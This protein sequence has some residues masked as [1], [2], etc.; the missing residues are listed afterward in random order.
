MWEIARQLSVLVLTVSLLLSLG[1]QSGEQQKNDRFNSSRSSISWIHPIILSNKEV[2]DSTLEYD[3]YRDSCPQAEYIVRSSIRFLYKEQPNVAPALLRL[4]FHDCFIQGCDASVLL[5]S[6]IDGNQSEKDTVPNQTLKGFHVI[7]NIKAEIEAVCPATV[8]CADI[9]VLAAR[10]GLVLAG[11]P[12]Y[13]LT[14]GRRDSLVS[15]ANIAAS[16]VPSP[17]DDLSK[18]LTSFASKGFDERETVSLLGAHSVG[19]AHCQFFRSRLYNFSGT[20]LPDPSLE[21]EFLHLMRSRCQS[22]DDS[23]SHTEEPGMSMGYDGATGPVFGTNYY[24]TLV[25]GKGIL[26]ADQ[27]LMAGEGTASWVEAYAS[28]ES[29]FRRDFAQVMMKLSSLRVLTKPLGQ[30]RLNCSRVA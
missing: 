25:L 7:E 19:V 24:N 6:T 15:F 13:P 21:P 16:E 18:T 30:I 26:H 28:D 14:T 10:D 4:L 20:G 27:Q 1:N 5:D 17:Q 29:L 2:I 9:L 22:S 23:K 12:Y 3:Y 11:G 8:S